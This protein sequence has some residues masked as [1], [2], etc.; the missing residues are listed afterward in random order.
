VN[1]KIL[2]VVLA[3]AAGIGVYTYWPLIAPYLPKESQPPI[4]VVTAAATT[5][6]A[7]PPV[8][9]ATP[10]AASPEASI[11]T[12]EAAIPEPRFIDPFALR[13]AL[14]SK[15]VPGPAAPGPPGQE[16]PAVKPSQPKL[17]GIWVD[18]SMRVAFISGQALN[19]GGTIMGWKVT[20]ISKDRVTLQKGRSV[21]I[22]RMEGLVK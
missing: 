10:E 22:L 21:K 4:A 14:K 3:L 11:A 5:T 9:E 13:T 8:A 16:K 1:N 18:S 6:T 2:V 20:S 7:P 15:Y 19:T 12:A 17:E